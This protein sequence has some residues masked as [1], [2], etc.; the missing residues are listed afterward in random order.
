MPFT[1][2]RSSR[3][4]LMKASALVLAAAG[5]T[6]AGPPPPPGGWPHEPAGATGIVDWGFDQ[7]V[8]QSSADQS[9]PGSPGWNI[10][11]NNQSVGSNGVLGGVSLIADPTAPFSP[12]NVYQFFYP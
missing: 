12:P 1:F 6:C 10:V 8:P 9:I 4:A 5:F 2:K 3:L 7:P 11:Y